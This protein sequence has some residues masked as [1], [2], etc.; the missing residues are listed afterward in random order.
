[1]SQQGTISRFTA[2]SCR[3]RKLIKNHGKVNWGFV[4]PNNPIVSQ[5]N[6]IVTPV[7]VPRLLLHWMWSSLLTFWGNLMFALKASVSKSFTHNKIIIFLLKLKK[8]HQ[9]PPKTKPNQKNQLDLPPK[10][11]KTKTKETNPKKTP[12][13]PERTK[14]QRIVWG[15]GS[16]WGCLMGLLS[17]TILESLELETRN[18]PLQREP[19]SV[20]LSQ[21]QTNPNIWGERI[22]EHGLSITAQPWTVLWH[23]RVSEKWHSCLLRVG[24]YKAPGTGDTHRTPWGGS[25]SRAQLIRLP[26]PCFF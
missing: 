8:K 16:V 25:R 6:G 26:P 3:F 4:N 10:K 17:V 14:N 5:I 21:L 24:Y 2:G 18:S 19:R 15:A 23:C 1:M 20:P 12:K 11:T 9:K 13:T 7:P 22:T